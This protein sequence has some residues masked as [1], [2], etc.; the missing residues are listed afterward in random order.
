MRLREVQDFRAEGLRCGASRFEK[1][2]APLRTP[3]NCGYWAQVLGLGQT[4]QGFG[5]LG[6]QGLGLRVGS[7]A[8]DP[9]SWADFVVEGQARERRTTAGLGFRV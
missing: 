2:L 8:V 1:K 7:F 6:F 3:K 5:G 9:K 4:M